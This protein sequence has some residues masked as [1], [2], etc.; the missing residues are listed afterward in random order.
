ML[1]LKHIFDVMKSQ[2]ICNK[3]VPLLFQPSQNFVLG[4][5][6]LL[7]MASK[8]PSISIDDAVLHRLKAFTPFAPLPL[9]KITSW[10]G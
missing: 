2:V 9:L 4:E 10:T 3:V 7:A 8:S 6:T 1:F 5:H